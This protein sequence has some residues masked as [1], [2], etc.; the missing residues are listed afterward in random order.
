MPHNFM[1]PCSLITRLI[2]TY[3]RFVVQQ[4]LL[5]GAKKK[6]A[7]KV[8]IAPQA[9]RSSISNINLSLSGFRESTCQYHSTHLKAAPVSNRPVT[10]MTGICPLGNSF[11]PGTI[12]TSSESLS[13]LITSC[14]CWCGL[15]LATSWGSSGDVMPCENFVSS[16]PLSTFLPESLSYPDSLE[17]RWRER[18]RTAES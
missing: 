12:P 4:R 8:P 17:L 10:T 5:H 14:R 16:P 6:Q 9:E 15:T 1:Y 13:C 18:R 2:T 7:R 11:H 3:H